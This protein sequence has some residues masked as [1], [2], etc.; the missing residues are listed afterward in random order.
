M[1]WFGSGSANTH[2]LCPDLTLDWDTHFKLLG[3]DFH[4]N[5]IGMECNYENKVKEI[6]NFLISGSTEL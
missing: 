1:V 3:I 4:N 6:K 5:L 2:Q